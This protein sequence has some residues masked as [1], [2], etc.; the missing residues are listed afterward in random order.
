MLYRKI[1][2]LLRT[3]AKYHAL[4][5]AR[6]ARLVGPADLRATDVPLL[7]HM[8][9]VGQQWIDDMRAHDAD[10][11]FRMGFHAVPSMPRLHLH[12]ISQVITSL[13]ALLMLQRVS[14]L[15]PSHCLAMRIV[16]QE[17]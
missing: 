17:A 11:V 6:E 16:G 13:P 8:Q 14:W 7:Q 9:E 3:Q 4:V 5:V 10:A 1:S 12:V 2:A 15:S